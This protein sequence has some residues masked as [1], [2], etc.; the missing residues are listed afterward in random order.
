MIGASANPRGLRPLWLLGLLIF[1][2]GCGGHSAPR[3]QDRGRAPAGSGFPVTLTDAQGIA[4]TVPRRPERILSSSPVVTEIL[5][6]VGAGD[7]VV[8]VSDQCN[9]PPEVKKLPRIGGFFSPSIERALAAKPDLVVASRGNPPDFLASMRAYGCPVFAI[10]PKTLD[11]IYDVILQVSRLVGEEENGKRLV[12]NM[13]ARLA[14]VAAKLSDVPESRRPTA[15]IFLQVDPI[16]TAGAG[17]FQDDVIRAAGARNAAGRL[18][19]FTSF[20]GESL[21]AADPDYLI[22][23]TMEGDPDRMKREVL[24]NPVY[25]E[26]SAVKAGRIIVL[27][28]D[29]IMRAGPRVVDAVEQLARALYP[30]RF[31]QSAHTSQ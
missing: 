22:L 5:F 19:G 11:D 1:A 30:D 10:D 15:F 21:M 31:T 12:E 18:H 6:A 7:R 25:R 28:G 20:G 26:L 29:E 23:S 27:D 8:A 2:V 24:A 16:W 14:A 3:S 4:V 13:K 17:T 9:Y